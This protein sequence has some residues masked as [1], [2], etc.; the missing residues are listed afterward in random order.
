M[1]PSPGLSI[2]K[3]L[4]QDTL[5]ALE[6]GKEVDIIKAL[7]ALRQV[8]DGGLSELP[9][10]APASQPLLDFINFFQQAIRDPSPATDL[11]ANLKLYP[12]MGEL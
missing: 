11:P 4:L 10:K 8:M 1:I 3:A 5:K 9:V 6:N 12:A 7:T 2:P